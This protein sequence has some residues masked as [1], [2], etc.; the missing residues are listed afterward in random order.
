[1]HAGALDHPRRGQVRV[2]VL[3]EAVDG[4]VEQRGA[5]GGAALLLRAAP[6]RRTGRRGHRAYRSQHTCRLVCI[7]LARSRGRWRFRDSMSVSTP[8]FNTDAIGG[9][10]DPDEF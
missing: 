10:G 4:R 2:A 1:G 3:D 7:L 9:W 5:C 6:L 8:E